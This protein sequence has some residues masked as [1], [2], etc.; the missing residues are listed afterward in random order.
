MD[1]KVIKPHQCFLK[2]SY[3]VLI[4]LNIK[5]QPRFSPKSNLDR[6]RS[7]GLLDTKIYRNKAIRIFY[8]AA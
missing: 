3:A 6:H 1:S 2:R 8:T 4:E 5:F 7:S